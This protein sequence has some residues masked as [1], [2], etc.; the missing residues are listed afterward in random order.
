MHP[1]STPLKSSENLT[2]FSC[3][4]EVEKGCIGNEWVDHDYDDIMNLKMF[5]RYMHLS[6]FCAGI[7]VI[8]SG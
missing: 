7:E 4:Q 3:F 8:V 2:V 5:L 6:N 1:F